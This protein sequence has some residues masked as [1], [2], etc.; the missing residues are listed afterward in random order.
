[1]LVPDTQQGCI[2][3]YKD[4]VAGYW[5]PNAAA[6]GLSPAD[7]TSINAKITAAET[8]LTNAFAAKQ[9]SKNKTMILQNAIEQLRDVGASLIA[10]IRGKAL[11][12]GDFTIYT[13]ANIPPPTQGTSQGPAVQPTDLGAFIDNLGNVQL[14]WQGSLAGGTFFTVWRKLSTE[15]S[16][17][18]MGSVVSKGFADSTIPTGTVSA[19]YY[20]VA[21]RSGGSSPATEPITVLFGSQSMAA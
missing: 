19:N 21:T 2:T 9:E 7:L 3:F 12:T 16:W 15:S 18:Q 4:E 20:V 1:M 14:S 8:A 13:K 11:Q 6:I 5:T 10:V 17:R